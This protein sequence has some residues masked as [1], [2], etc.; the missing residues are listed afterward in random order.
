MKICS[1][2]LIREMQVK[3]TK[4][5]HLKPVRIT[6]NNKKKSFVKN[7]EILEWQTIKVFSEVRPWTADL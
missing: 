7:E 4:R 2:S 1:I 6:I 5:Y 3:T